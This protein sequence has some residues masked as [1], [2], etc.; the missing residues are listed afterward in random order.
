MQDAFQELEEFQKK[1]HRPQDDV[2][3]SLP[4]PSLPLSL[5]PSL[6]PSLPLSFLP[7]PSLL[8]PSPSLPIHILQ[9][10]YHIPVS[11][12]FFRFWTW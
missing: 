6:I 11:L 3:N 8:P 1:L 4:L 9:L 7:S 12:Q 10:E 5:P 2:D